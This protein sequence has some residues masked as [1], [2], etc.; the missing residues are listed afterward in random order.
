MC[1]LTAVCDMQKVLLARFKQ[2]FAEEADGA[3]AEDPADGY[4][5]AD[6]GTP[7]KLSISRGKTHR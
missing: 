5:I 2:P 6:G 4:H 7:R 3:A 1:T